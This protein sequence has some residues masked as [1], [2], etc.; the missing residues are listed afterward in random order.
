M[1]KQC[2]NYQAWVAKKEKEKRGTHSSFVCSEVNI[3]LVPIDTWWI[4]SGATTHVSV[5]MQ[6]CLS[7]RKP[8]DVER[9]IYSGDGN[10]TEVEVI[11]HFKVLLSTGFYLD[12]YET[13][14]V[15][16]FRRNLIFVYS[17]DKNGFSCMFE[18]RNFRL[19]LVSKSV[20]IGKMSEVD[21]LYALS[22]EASYNES[23]HTSTRNVRQ[24][25][26]HK[27]SSALWHRRLGRISQE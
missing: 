18:N 26:T 13:F 9:Y 15:P 27:N 8:S 6:G 19:F 3:V 17:L 5:S 11:G 20:G 2:T 22:N 16:S 12:L 7:H 23:L 1:K 14:V 4:N 24:K 25:L 10:M 21:K